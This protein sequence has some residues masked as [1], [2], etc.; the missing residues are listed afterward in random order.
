V[1]DGKLI[2]VNLS[3]DY[4][5]EQE[6]GI[7]V[8]RRHFGLADDKSVIGIQRRTITKCP[9]V[10]W[11]KDRWDSEPG[12]QFFPGKT[13]ASN[14][15]LMLGRHP[16]KEADLKDGHFELNSWRD[17]NIGA[18]WDEGSFG[19]RVKGESYRGY[20][21]EIYEAFKKLDIAIF[22]GKTMPGNPF[23]NAGLQL[24]IVSRIPEN[25]KKVMYDGDV[26]YNKLQEASAA[27]GI[28]AELRAAGKSWFALSPSWADRFKSTKDG[29]VK[30]SYPVMY[31]LNPMEQ[32]INNS[33]WFTVEQLRDW[34]KGT[35]PVM[36]RK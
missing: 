35:G 29:D 28:E 22:L 30:T 17:E 24:M 15:Y 19:I 9:E 32:H 33:G 11:G 2:G 6:W 1:E 10:V 13:K 26:D 27:T 36:M 3:A 25:C 16:I 8:I 31:W 12:L 4:C 23:E 21:T 34:A 7:K 20:L 14:M 18:A 5:A